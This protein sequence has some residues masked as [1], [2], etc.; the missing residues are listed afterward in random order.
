MYGINMKDL[1][2]ERAGYWYPVGIPRMG[3]AEISY[4][5]ISCREKGKR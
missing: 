2:K 3:T 5:S 4:Y 1:Y